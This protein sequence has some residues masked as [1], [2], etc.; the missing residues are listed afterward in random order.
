MPSEKQTNWFDQASEYYN[1]AKFIQNQPPHK[2]SKVN[3]DI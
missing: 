3:L 1:P 2:I